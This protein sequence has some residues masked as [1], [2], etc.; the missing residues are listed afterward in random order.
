MPITSNTIFILDSV[1][2]LIP[3]F[4]LFGLFVKCSVNTVFPQ[5][6]MTVMSFKFH[7]VFNDL[8][9]MWIEWPL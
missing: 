6:L 7:F 2:S 4:L 5:M 1:N 9:Q 8:I 3:I